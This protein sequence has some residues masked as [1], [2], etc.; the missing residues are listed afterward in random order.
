MVKEN[1]LEG[2][3]SEAL[4]IIKKI[5]PNLLKEFPQIEFFLNVQHF[6]ELIKRKNH[7]EAITF[8]KSSISFGEEEKFLTVKG[9]NIEEITLDVLRIL[10]YIIIK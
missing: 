8:A 3:C 9:N 10:I 7:V 6:I 2:K 4:E 1:I 5:F